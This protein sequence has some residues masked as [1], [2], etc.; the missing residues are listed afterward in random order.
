[1]PGCAG[2]SASPCPFFLRKLAPSSALT[3]RVKSS[4]PPKMNQ[5]FFK[6]A[7]CKH[8]YCGLTSKKFQRRKNFWG[9]HNTAC[10]NIMTEMKSACKMTHFDY[11]YSRGAAKRPRAAQNRNREVKN[12]GGRGYGRTGPTWDI[13]RRIPQPVERHRSPKRPNF[14]CMV[15][16]YGPS[17][18]QV[19][20]S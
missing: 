9:N 3:A 18:R 14:G 17:R 10:I 6:F 20:G 5:F 8:F 12:A 1:M 4:G 13:V 15:D 16:R 7:P 2:S 11:S 19:A